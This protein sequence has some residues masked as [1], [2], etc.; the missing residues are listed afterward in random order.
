MLELHVHDTDPD[1]HWRHGVSNP[2]RSAAA[3][4][5]SWSVV[6]G[7]SGATAQNPGGSQQSASADPSLSHGPLA[8]TGIQVAVLVIVALA[9]LA[10]R[11]S[12]AGDDPAPET[13]DLAVFLREQAVD[14][15]RR[16]AARDLGGLDACAQT[17][18]GV[19]E[20]R[21]LPVERV[22]AR[23]L[24]NGDRRPTGSGIAVLIG[25]P[26]ELGVVDVVGDGEL[27]RVR[28]TPGLPGGCTPTASSTMM[29]P[30]PASRLS[31]LFASDVMPV[32]CPGTPR[33]ALRLGCRA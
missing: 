21:P 8:L 32:Y 2:L 33:T 1:A 19:V 31:R 17:V 11:R 16:G 6:S 14:P 23:L 28:S 25:S 30:L 13:A 12:P 3:G 29:P 20:R 27:A 9:L 10:G 24:W 5:S 22:E 7:S 18:P 15:V 4:G 26:E